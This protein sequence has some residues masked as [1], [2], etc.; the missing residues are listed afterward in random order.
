MRWL[1]KDHWRL[2]DEVREVSTDLKSNSAK[3]HP[4]RIAPKLRPHV[5]AQE[6]A[7]ALLQCVEDSQSTVWRRSWLTLLDKRPSRGRGGAE[8]LARQQSKV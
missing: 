2:R 4:G 7:R 6:A 3:T 1:R 5:K 8:S